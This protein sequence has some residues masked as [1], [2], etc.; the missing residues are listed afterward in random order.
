MNF[1]LNVVL[2]VVV[3]SSTK[4]SRWITLSGCSPPSV[5]AQFTD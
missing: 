2:V 5:T 3:L 1:H 4:I